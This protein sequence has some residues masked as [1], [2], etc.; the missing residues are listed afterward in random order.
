MRR[1]RETDVARPVVEHF[2]EMGYEVYQEVK[3]ESGGAIADIVAMLGRR[4]HIVEVKATLSLDV[5]AQALAWRSAAEWVSVAV[6]QSAGG[7]AR[8]RALAFDIASSLGLG[9]LLVDCRYPADP[10]VSCRVSPMLFRWPARDCGLLQYS[11]TGSAPPTVRESLHIRRWLTDEQRTFCAAGAPARV[12]RYTPWR[13][14][15][16]QL[17]NVVGEH[18]DG[19][20]MKEAVQQVKHHY[21]CD[22]TARAALSKWIRQGMIQGI[23]RDGH[24]K[25]RRVTPHSA[26]EAEEGGK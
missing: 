8:G 4:A 2:A 21:G 26:R 22:T 7:N 25:L 14:T 11:A 12:P 6:P 13:A 18:P 3:V 16:N 10:S 9:V 19:I 24:G 20:S 23:T 1:L 5:L 17:L 15:V